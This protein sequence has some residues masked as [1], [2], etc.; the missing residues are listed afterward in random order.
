MK[1]NYLEVL[2]FTSLVSG[3]LPCLF[4]QTTSLPSVQQ[5]LAQPLQVPAVSEFQMQEFLMARLP[6]L[7]PPSTAEQ[8]RAKEVALRRHILD[9]VA[10][11]G[12]PREWIDS[13][14]HFELVGVITSGHGYVVRKLRYEIVPGFMATALLYI[15]DKIVGRVPAVLNV[16]GHEPAGI[17]V[18][19]EQKRCINLAKQGI[20][21]LNLQWM[22]FGQLSQPGNMHDFGA[23]L[24]LVGSNALGIFY[25]AMRRGLDY[26]TTLPEVDA[27]R[28][29][30]TG[31]SGGGWQT[32]VLGA[33]DERVAVSVEVAGIGSRESNLTRPADTDE[34]E[35]SPPD[36][37]K[38]FDYPEFVAMRAPRPTLLIH[39]GVDSCCFRASLVKPYIYDNV[40][41]FFRLFGKADALGWHENLDPGTHNYQLDNRQQAYAFFAKNFGMPVVESE[42]FSGD[43]IRTPEELAIDV[44]MDSLTLLS[45]ARKMAAAIQRE[46]VP[47]A[48]ASR[49]AWVNV[50][51]KQLKSTLRYDGVSTVRALRLANGRGLNFDSIYYRFDLSNKLSAIGMWFKETAARDDQPLTIVLNDKGLKAAE[52]VVAEHV[53][54]GEQVLALDLLFNGAAAPGAPDP[55]DW[56]MLADASGTRPLGLEV[57]QLIAVA[58]WLRGTSVGGRIQIET[59]G[60]RNQ[61]IA[62]S[63]AAI[64]PSTFS[65]VVSKNGMES[66]NYLVNTPVPFRSAPD[67]FCLDLYKNFDLDTLKVLAS[68]VKVSSSRFAGT[69]GPWRTKSY[70][71]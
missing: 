39:N 52:E 43:E 70:M 34:I 60:I 33:L 51:R 40:V 18:E 20:V 28:I 23:Q 61:V 2:L 12:W 69:S 66:L 42:T 4:G 9:E 1:G 37:N 68:P 6:P 3:V 13:A 53:D 49:D 38:D 62:L 59:D 64:E 16:V 48:G 27:A 21:A 55:S 44:P 45:L 14:P 58:H 57:A 46:P 5:T 41:P 24:D 30:M 67:L 47:A 63:A 7:P 35:E 25:L 54:R 50:Q 15:P 11:H 29:G 10:Y 65:T 56:V 8:W 19:Y 26:L 22:G 36:L 32:V 71:P 17:A 31:L